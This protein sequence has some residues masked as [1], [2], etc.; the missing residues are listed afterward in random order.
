M[1]GER[2][3]SVTGNKRE[4]FESTVVI[5]LCVAVAIVIGLTVGTAHS[6]S[7]G[8]AAAAGTTTTPIKHVVVI[9]DENISFDHYFGRYPKAKNP[10]NEPSFTPL[11]STPRVRGLTRKLRKNN[12]NKA[13]P[14]RLDRSQAVTCDMDHQYT[15]EQ[16]AFH[17]GKMDRFVEYTSSKKPSCDRKTVMDYF[18]GNTVTGLW[19]YAQH[20]ALNDNSF[21]STF[22]PSTPGALNLVSGQTHG[23]TPDQVPGKVANGTVIGDPNPLYDD[24]SSGTTVSMSGQNVGDLLNAKSIT[25]GWFQGGFDPSS[26]ALDGTASCATSHKNIA[27]KGSKDYVPHHE[28]FQYYASTSNPHHLPP[29]ST[30]G[31]SDQA[32]HQYSLDSF[33]TAADAG[34]LP[35]VSFLKAPA[36]QD[37][38]AGNSDPL[39][40][41]HF[42]VKTINRLQG[43]ASWKSTAVIIAY[44]DSDG[45]YDHVMGPT[46][47]SSFDAKDALDGPGLCNGQANGPYQDRCGYG[48]RLP[49]LVI[50]PYARQNFVDHTRTDQTSVIRFIE[51]NWTLGRIG[52]SSFDAKAGPL[53]A[54]FDFSHR[55]R[56]TVILSPKTGKVVHP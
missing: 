5:A 44:D 51:N 37:A 22:G 45:W 31:K 27:G 14:A 36:Y 32:N 16:R 4:S 54:M 52:D 53:T 30:I 43:L 46:V 7:A 38:H 25:W 8:V 33:W 47:S 48:P 11:A 15:A 28:P 29:T 34:N 50:S 18:D 55:R 39:D 20:F 21:A 41:Q 1:S 3:S 35:A 17:G 10:K 40:E 42:I 19:N 26:V 6:R 2:M 13:N 12:P 24:C 23:A 9:F 49:L 56:D